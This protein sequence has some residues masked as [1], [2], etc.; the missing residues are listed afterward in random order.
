MNSRL[1]EDF[2]YGGAPLPKVMMGVE[3]PFTPI[4]TVEGL[5]GAGK[6]TFTAALMDSMVRRGL[7][8]GV[9]SFPRYGSTYADIASDALHGGQVGMADS[10]HAMALLFAL[11]RA[12]AADELADMTLV[13]D[14]IILD[15][16]V[17]S[18]AAYTAA[19]LG[20]HRKDE[21]IRWVEELEFDTLGL[22]VPTLQV[23]L[24]TPGEVAA[25]RARSREE[26]DSTR[27]RDFYERDSRL[28]ED[29]G[30]AYRYLADTNWKSEWLV[31]GLDPDTDEIA[32]RIA[33][34]IDST[35][36]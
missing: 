3:D 36:I 17:A 13:N 26:S 10:P 31:C 7:T 2:S 28:Q 23:F 34:E 8:V 19:R 15:R 24:D 29:T 18:N 9:T 32:D 5:D 16:Y 21:T 20:L 14:V 6:N 4:I 11:D 12:Q 22:P 30:E 27:L 33:R 1:A 35:I 25:S